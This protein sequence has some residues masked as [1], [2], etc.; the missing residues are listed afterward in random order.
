MKARVDIWGLLIVTAI[1][2]LV[3]H[4]AAQQTAVEET[5]TFALRP[6]V[7]IPGADAVN[8]LVT[9]TT[10]NVSVTLRGP[11]SALREVGNG[12]SIPVDV[13]FP[14]LENGVGETTRPVASLIESYFEDRGVAIVSVDPATKSFEITSISSRKSDVTLPQIPRV[15][16]DPLGT[17]ISPQT[18]D[19][20]VPKNRRI[21]STE[22][23]LPA[24]EVQGL[25]PGARRTF[26]DVRVLVTLDDET[27]VPAVDIKPSSVEVVVNVRQRFDARQ[28]R[29][30]VQLAGPGEDEY[31][32]V[33][34][35]PAL[36]VVLEVPTDL[37]DLLRSDAPGVR[38]P[39]LIGLVHLGSAEKEAAVASGGP[40]RKP[41]GLFVAVTGGGFR[42]LKSVE[43]PATVEYTVT[44]TKP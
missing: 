43:S 9:P 6:T 19:V 23:R 2:A 33:F 42:V 20:R 32:V 35:P 16:L 18:V 3:W 24:N 10:V 29:V 7:D 36:D 26:A 25:E 30:R 31:T 37:S 44:R 22:A 11:V 17:T 27:V 15:D 40:G 14:V 1:T 13:P 39:Q 34:N 21:I 5:R 28:E 41:I 4:R 38:K 12:D 8:Y